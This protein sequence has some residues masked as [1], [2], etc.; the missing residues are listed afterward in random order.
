MQV[1]LDNGATTKMSRNAINT[2]L[3]HMDNIF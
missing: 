3:W 2:M 1:Y